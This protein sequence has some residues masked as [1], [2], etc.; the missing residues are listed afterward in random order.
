MGEYRL[1]S[2]SG[3]L[4]Y[5]YPE[6]SLERGIEMGVDML[7]VDGGSV[8]P[9]PHYL[10]SGKTLNSR[11]AM[12]RDIKLM[13]RAAVKHGIPVTIGTCGGA[14]GEPH[15]DIMSDIVREI[16][17]EDGL[18]FKM[19]VIHAEQDKDWLKSEVA[20]GKVRPMRNVGALDEDTIDKAERIVGCMGP[21][22][23]MAALD[24]GAQV[25]LGGRSTDPAPFAACAMRAQM[26]AAPS[27]YAGKMLECA[28]AGAWP[29]G[30]D[31]MHVTITD[32]GVVCEPPNPIRQCTPMSLANQSLHENASPTLFQEPGGM[33]DA[34][35]CVFDAV[36]DR[37]ARVSGMEWRP[38]DTY[39]VKI[40]GAELIGYRAITICG[41]RD[42][43]LIDQYE[44]YIANVRDNIAQKA[45]AVGISPDSYHLTYRTY[46]LNG[47]MGE[48][49]P[50]A[51]S[52]GHELGLL[53][54]VIANTQEEANAVLSIARVNTMHIDFPGR[55][56]KEGNMAF[57]FSP[58]DIECGP[59][60]RFSVYHIVEPKDPYAMF[61][62]DYETVGG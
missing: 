57:P 27:W 29:K 25:V 3:I 40:E 33:L 38:D 22:P 18:T 36:S 6:E 19:A 42:P 8:D 26:D 28:A 17:R 41:T 46:G 54:E 31:C 5:G 14:G 60:Y 7:G 43:I 47:V 52:P 50:L 51:G 48:R 24:A 2:T 32:D 49:E 16:A 44:D 61:P 4:G 59:A 20:A 37:A 11:P 15:L 34:S 9:G 13:L 58:S 45:A 21:E 12:K 30:H 1:L 56:C 10:G 55:L 39:T 23:Y 62:I 53:V 35:N